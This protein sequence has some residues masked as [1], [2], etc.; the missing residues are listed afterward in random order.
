M[1]SHGPPGKDASALQVLRERKRSADGHQLIEE[2]NEHDNNRN[3]KPKPSPMV[4]FKC[5]ISDEL[6]VDPV[7]AEDGNIYERSAIE[8]WLADHDTSPATNEQM[9]K[10][11]IGSV[12]IKNAIEGMVDNFQKGTEE[13]EELVTHWKQRNEEVRKKKE[14][15]EEAEQGDLVA[16]EMAGACYSHGL[17]GFEEDE[18]KAFKWNKKAADAGSIIGMASAGV[19]LA[20]K[21]DGTTMDRVLALSFTS[22]TATSQGSDAA[23]LLLGKSYAKGLFGLPRDKTQAKRLLE[24]GLSG[25]CP[26]RHTTQW[27]RDNSQALLHELND[28]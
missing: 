25:N 5:M 19:Y 11:L 8:T 17:K 21:P 22:M 13:E 7:M 1:S 20:E 15:L 3:K 14:L 23:C 2:D 27:F 12:R 10:N 24:L 26:V 4:E 28:S 16:M 6:P 18:E 9:G